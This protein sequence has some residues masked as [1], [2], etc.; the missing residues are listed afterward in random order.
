MKS[1]ALAL[2]FLLPCLTGL[3]A[4]PTAKGVFKSGPVEMPVTSA[5]AFRGR[6]LFS[7]EREALIVAIS[8]AKFA[9]GVVEAYSDR[10]RA[11]DRR[12][13]DDETVVVYLSFTPDGSWR[14]LSYYFGPGNGCGFC[15]SDGKSSVK[16]AEGR[17]AGTVTGGGKDRSFEVT[18]DVPI[19]SDDHGPVL[20]P[21]GGDPGKAY[22]AYHAA[23]IKGDLPAIR[24]LLPPD[25]LQQWEKAQAS[26][27]LP[28]F[29]N[30]LREE[31]GLRSVKVGKG[32]AK[33]D[34]AV[35]LVAGE[36]PSGPVAGEVTLL[37][38][39]GTWRVD[40]E[41]TDPKSD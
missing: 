20:P 16:L 34:R 3:A 6:D 12:F 8:H 4:E 40:D 35:L 17:L 21:D 15:T 13:R 22:L 2:S 32:W 1:S 39:K 28:K 14:G 5:V 7:P 36:G 37:R 11:I 33:G 23:L 26:G 41:L 30:Y 18:L 29:L 19:A 25:R 38:E 31:H 27:N 24:T 10:K 9:A